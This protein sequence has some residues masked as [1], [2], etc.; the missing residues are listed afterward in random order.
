MRETDPTD[1]P[2]EIDPAHFRSV[3]GHYPTGVCV[4]SG[5]RE[6]GSAAGLAIGTFTSVSLDPP[7]V[8]FCPDKRSS[9]WPLMRRSGRF[10]VNVLGA[11][12]HALSRKFA[13]RGVDKF[14]GVSH[15]LSK[16]GLPVLDGVVAAIE[17]DI[18]AEHDA[19]DHLFVI[20]RV[21]SLEILRPAAPLLYFKGSYGTFTALDH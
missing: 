15:S 2:I 10:C 19:G 7:L 18:A 12:Q 5:W 11:D 16:H 14:H 8:G 20:G 6:P 21:L 3:L 4:V 1:T 17:C 9:S 13:T